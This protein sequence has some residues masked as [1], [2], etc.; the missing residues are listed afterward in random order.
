[1]DAG[2]TPNGTHDDVSAK[3]EIEELRKVYGETVALNGV[4][5][6]VRD[7]EFF[8]LLGP[9]GSGKSTLLRILGGLETATDGTVRIGGETIGD[10]PPEKRPTS[11]VFQNLSLFPHMSVMENLTFGLRMQ[12]VPADERNERAEEMIELLGLA[13]YADK[14]IEEL[15][16]GEQQRIALGRSLLTNPD[17]LLLDEPLSSLDVR[18]KKEMMLELKRIHDEIESTFFYVTHD[19]E[20]ALSSSDRIA[21]MNDGEIVQTGTPDEIYRTPS[22]TFVADFVGDI[23]L[24]PGTVTEVRDERATVDVEGHSIDGLLSAAHPI[25]PDDAVTIVIRPERIAVVDDSDAIITGTVTDRVYQGQSV[26]YTVT[27]ESLETEL[28]IREPTDEAVE[29]SVGT[30]VGLSWSVEAARV[31]TE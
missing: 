31:L 20:V 22:T 24:L 7:G 10:T 23:N 18:L 25:E 9:S 13:G 29:Y 5:L 19:Q 15:S 3:V 30:A 12:N 2:A 26:L 8:T 14:N 21:V 16:G 17:I 4:S 28:R 1:M 6:T 27:P 11:T